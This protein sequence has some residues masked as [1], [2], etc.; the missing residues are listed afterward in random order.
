MPTRRVLR[1]LLLIELAVVALIV[2]QWAYVTTYRLFLDRAIDAQRSAA[3]QQFGIGGSR[4][5]PQI[6]TR[7]AERLAFAS[8][9]PAPLTFEGELRPTK[10]PIG[11]AV[12]WRD[13]ATQYVLETGVVTNR[14]AISRPAPSTLGV[15]EL[16]TDGPAAW[17][18]VRLVRGMHVKPHLV[19]LLLL[20]AASVSI[21]RRASQRERRDMR[22]AVFKLVALV[23]TVVAA[24]CAC[25]FALRAMGGHGPAGM[26]AQR[27][28]LGE[29][30]PDE[31][32][33]DSPVY[34]RRLRPNVDAENAWQ[35]GDIVRMGFIAPAVSP[36][37]W[38]RF[39]F[40]TDAEGFRNAAVRSHVDIAALGDSFTDALTVN[41]D[42]AW[43]S[44]LRE[45]LGVAVQ[46]Y[47]T[48]GF[49]PQQ[50]YRVLRDY[51]L[52]HRPSTVVLAYF[53]GN[54]I[55]DA[56]R[57]DRF[58]HGEI[59]SPSLGW[60]IKDVYSR[61]DTWFVTSASSASAKWFASRDRPFIVNASAAM[62]AVDP[63]VRAA[64]PFDRGLF[65]LNVQGRTLQFALMPPY[66]NIMNLSDRELR[67]RI[68]WRL[69]RESI[70]AMDRA[71]RAS[72]TTFV[73]MFLPFKSQVLWPLLERSMTSN[74]LHAA[75]RFYLS[76]YGR[77][78]DPDVLRRNRLAQNAMMHD[79]CVS[80]GIPF[81]DATP[82]LQQRVESGENVYF[83]DD[84][85]LN[86]RGLAIVGDTIANF[87]QAR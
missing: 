20:A 75:L 79:L 44:R 37:V 18:D 35:Y 38:H 25:E 19:V 2:R 82:A 70:L 58:E 72:G 6:I 69:T 67:G 85:H 49:G 16:E 81:L 87:L 51:V 83:T 74:D 13:G 34:G 45:R 63:V 32:W 8:P 30:W 52:P 11:Y 31:R 48:A 43:P 65:T 26:L 54:D 84:S 9:L 80:N 5:V 76:D 42:A 86:E 60:Q 40:K 39:A 28:D 10:A 12:K 59:Q 73:V 66:L 47:G 3:T 24:T 56:E 57:F 29:L 33:E 1:L 78:I 50:E 53:A 23:G 4:V 27:R 68:G 36:G 7:D 14:I 55:I 77:P 46:N 61:A 62:P 17:I 15:L 21:S 71:S 64:A 22:A 41:A